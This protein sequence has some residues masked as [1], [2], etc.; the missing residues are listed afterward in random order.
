M[1]LARIFF[2]GTLRRWLRTPREQRAA[3]WQHTLSEERAARWLARCMHAASA[4]SAV[5]AVM[6][7]A[8]PGLSV[9]GPRCASEMDA[10]TSAPGTSEG[11]R[12][13]RPAGAA[14]RLAASPKAQTFAVAIRR[15]N[16][17]WDQAQ[18][19]R[20]VSTILNTDDA[21]AQREILLA[22]TASDEEW[23]AERAARG[24]DASSSGAC[25]WEG[26]PPPLW[27]R[28]GVGDMDSLV[29]EDVGCPSRC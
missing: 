8:A 16:P 9:L 18:V 3:N 22:I 28:R 26:S 11:K 20:A 10:S 24:G 15:A 19:D 27:A 6:H 13:V 14:A 12:R 29:R 2:G 4:A 5:D 1:A 23:A 17:D 7:A 25:E 21:G